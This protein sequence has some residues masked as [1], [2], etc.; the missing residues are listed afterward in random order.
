MKPVLFKCVLVVV[1]LWSSL[2][3]GSGLNSAE[4]FY[5]NNQFKDALDAYQTYLNEQPESFNILYNIGNCYF[6]LNQF[7]YAIAYYKKA[8]QLDPSNDD[9][10]NNLNLSRRSL[11]VSPSTEN[12]LSTNVFNWIDSISLTAV[13]SVVMIVLL[14]FNG[15]VFYTLKIR[16]TELVVN[17]IYTTLVLLIVSGS[18]LTYKF[19]L[20]TQQ[21]AV[22]IS[23]KISVHEGPST[24]LPQ[25]F[26]LHEG[27]ELIIKKEVQQWS[28]IELDNGFQGW[29]ERSHLIKI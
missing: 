8:L 20:S 4:L 10:L 6:K 12:G 23:K 19:K 9:A 11:L 18:F 28:E 16:K 1:M 17:I 15:A 22:I 2:L 3:F 7:G 21:E 29:V 5:Q 14:V 25:L 13:Y 24:N 26:F 27:R